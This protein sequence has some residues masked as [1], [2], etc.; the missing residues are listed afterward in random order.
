MRLAFVDDD[1][2]RRRIRVTAAGKSNP[3]REKTYDRTPR[4]G[5]SERCSHEDE[6]SAG[7]PDVGARARG[8]RVG[9]GRHVWTLLIAAF[10][11]AEPNG[12][13]P[14]MRAFAHSLGA[15]GQGMTLLP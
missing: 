10:L 2:V 7:E 12:V 11:H 3:P 13:G 15:S 9:R 6:R 14:E 5:R 4:G 8:T 1:G